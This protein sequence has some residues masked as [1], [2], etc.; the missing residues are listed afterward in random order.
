MIAKAVVITA[1]NNK[2]KTQTQLITTAEVKSAMHSTCS[3]LRAHPRRVNDTGYVNDEKKKKKKKQ[4]I[5]QHD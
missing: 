1:L 2:K 5:T 4:V 3:L